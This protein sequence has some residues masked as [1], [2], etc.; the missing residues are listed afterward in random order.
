V[1]PAVTAVCVVA[2]VMF[3]ARQAIVIGRA[4]RRLTAILRKH[5][6]SRIQIVACF[7]SVELKLLVIWPQPRQGDRRR[8]RDR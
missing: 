8:T 6:P 2:A 7:D 1:H 3:A 4:C 5:M